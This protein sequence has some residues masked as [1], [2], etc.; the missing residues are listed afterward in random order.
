MD[1]VLKRVPFSFGKREEVLPKEET[2]SL[3]DR[4]KDTQNALAMAVEKF[5]AET[6]FAMIDSHIYQMQSLEK[7]LSAL[8]ALAKEEY[9]MQEEPLEVCSA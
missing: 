5:D 2:V 8:F 1:A 6:D 7:R 3:E 9:R 4:I